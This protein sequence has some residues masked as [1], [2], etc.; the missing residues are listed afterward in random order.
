MSQQDVMKNGPIKR[1]KK[2][3]NRK[4]RGMNQSK[5]PTTQASQSIK[6]ETKANQ[7]RETDLAW[8]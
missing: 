5:R 1:G 8:D 3:I 4:G 2:W 6:G 7:E